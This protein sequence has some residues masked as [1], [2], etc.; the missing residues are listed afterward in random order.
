MITRHKNNNCYIIMEE[1]LGVSDHSVRHVK[2][3]ARHAAPSSKLARKFDRT[4]EENMKNVTAYVCWN[5][6]SLEPSTVE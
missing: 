6:E 5:P 4:N 2:L 3:V 1:I